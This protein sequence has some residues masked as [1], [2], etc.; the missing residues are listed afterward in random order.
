MMIVAPM[1]ESGIATTGTNT[2]RSEPIKRKITRITIAI[3]SISV[4]KT[5]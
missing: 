1:S 5:W 4:F 2:A 3:V